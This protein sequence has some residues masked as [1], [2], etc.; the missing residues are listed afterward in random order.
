MNIEF[1]Q[2]TTSD[3]T[4]T[5]DNYLPVGNELFYDLT[6]SIENGTTKTI[7]LNWDFDIKNAGG[8]TIAQYSVKDKYR[9]VSAALVTDDQI[10]DCLNES[11]ERAESRLLARCKERKIE[12]DPISMSEDLKEATTNDL[13][14]QIYS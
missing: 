1:A 5:S 4:L 10:K 12:I 8:E 6:A 9:I 11:K 2:L 3:F 7:I 14:E 13:M